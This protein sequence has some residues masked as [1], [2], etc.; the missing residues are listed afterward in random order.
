MTHELILLRKYRN[1]LFFRDLFYFSNMSEIKETTAFDDLSIVY[2]PKVKSLIR[3]FFVLLFNMIFTTLIIGV[4]MAVYM[5]VLKRELPT[6]WKSLLSLSAYVMM[7]FYT[8]RFAMRKVKQQQQ[9]SS[10]D[11]SFNKISIGLIPLAII[12]A[13]SLYLCIEPIA[14]SI[15]MP[16]E[17]RTFFEKAFRPDI[18][19][20]LMMVV[21]APVLE[22]ILCRG[23]VLKGLLENYPPRKAIVISALFFALIH[24]N[25]WQA[26]PAFFFGLFVGWVF[27]KTQSIIPGMIMHATVNGVSAF[28]LFLPED[29][30]ELSKMLGPTNYV[31]VC[32]AGLV[33][34]II[35][36]RVLT[37][38]R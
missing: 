12:S 31:L 20:V 27:Y 3:L 8:I 13:L 37:I 33:V 4:V 24:M 36:C 21:A 10:V 5:G 23:I 11:L 7:M 19:S 35:C 29:R 28:A 30:Q 22:E 2:Y 14:T 15:P 6:F 18:M 9:Q 38:R 1:F 34:F 26:I 25:P 32:L 17:V 16:G